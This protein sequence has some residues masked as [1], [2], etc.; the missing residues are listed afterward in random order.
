MFVYYNE[1][2]LLPPANEVCEGYVFTCVCHSVH[3][4]G[5]LPQ[6]MLGY[7][8]PTPPGTRHPPG[9]GTPLGPGTHLGPGTP[10]DQAPPWEQTLPSWEKTP[11][12][13]QVPPRIRHPPGSRHPPL[14]SACWEIWS[15]S[16]QYASYWYAILC[17][18]RDPL[19][20]LLN[21]NSY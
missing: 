2:L 3:R 16:G 21:H 19:C 18:K 15:T 13:D 14:R 20:N 7:H 11:P 17:C 10:R 5:G 6:S 8:T 1:Y 12:R 9:P 4:G